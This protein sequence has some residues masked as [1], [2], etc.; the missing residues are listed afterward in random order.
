MGSL[1]RD[2][3]DNRARA[4]AAGA[5]EAVVEA[6]AALREAETVQWMACEVLMLLVSDNDDNR[7]RIASAGGIEAV[8]EAMTAH[9]DAES[10]QQRACWA[11]LKLAKDTGALARMRAAGSVRLI[12]AAMAASD[13][14][15]NTKKWGREL[16]EK[17]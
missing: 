6:M 14:S 4:A 16:L 17:L 9:R 5:I 10:V 8:V 3:P 11:L 2:N 7:A 12:R 15:E 1:T 13:A